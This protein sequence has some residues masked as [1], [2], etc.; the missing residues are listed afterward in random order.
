M[1]SDDCDVCVVFDKT[2][3]RACKK[4]SSSQRLKEAGSVI[5]RFVRIWLENEDCEYLVTNLEREEFCTE[6][7]GSLYRMRWGIET[8]F[9]DLKNK[10]QIEN[11]TGQKP[12][13]MEQESA[14]SQKR[15]N[16]RTFLWKTGK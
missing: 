14:V 1:K 12:A 11:F 15:P 9:D 8:V 7:T 13:I 4:K 16:L 3:Y 2:R 6:E 5:L 10:M